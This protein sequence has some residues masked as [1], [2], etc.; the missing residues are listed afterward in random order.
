MNPLIHAFCERV[1]NKPL[2]NNKYTIII[3]NKEKGTSGVKD[4]CIYTDSSNTKFENG[5]N[6]SCPVL[7]IKIYKNLEK[8]NSN[9]QAEY[10]R[11]TMG[12]KAVLNRNVEDINLRVPTYS[13]AVLKSHNSNYLCNRKYMIA[14]GCFN[15]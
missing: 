11:L 3:S 5:A 6:T 7:N 13:Q 15:N 1:P 10:P 4:L 9:F 2:Y 14:E 12:T 8:H